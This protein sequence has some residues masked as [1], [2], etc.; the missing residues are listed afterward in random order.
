[1]YDVHLLVKQRKKSLEKYMT[2]KNKKSK[3]KVYF[4]SL[5]FLSILFNYN[6]SFLFILLN[7]IQFNREA[8]TN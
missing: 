1:M 4:E 6:G 3:N 8:A 7:Y 2:N 5:H